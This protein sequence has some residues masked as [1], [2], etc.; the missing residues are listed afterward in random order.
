MN[1]PASFRCAGSSS[2]DFRI[3]SAVA[4]ESAMTCSFRSSFAFSRSR[5]IS[6]SARAM[7]ACASECAWARISPA[8]FCP[9][10]TASWSLARAWASM[11]RR[12]C[13]SLAFNWSAA[14]CRRS[15]SANSP[16][17]LCR[18]FSSW[19]VRG[20]QAH[21]LR[22]Q[23]RIRKPR[24]WVP[25]MRMSIRFMR[26]PFTGPALC[27]G[28]P[29]STPYR[30]RRLPSSDLALQEEHGHERIDRERLGERGD[31]DHGELDLARGLRL[32]ADGLHGAL[33]DQAE[34]DARADGGDAD[35]DGKTEG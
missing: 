10:D 30:V 2:F 33:T 1:C 18:R 26:A 9:S 17:I 34:A 25:T 8:T 12:S 31:D 35:S 6:S 22:P 4:S 11:P 27:A 32:A 24:I 23:S 3:F 29:G 20:P 19:A 28:V 21:L 7:R 13:S 15:A 5:I 14:C 16:A